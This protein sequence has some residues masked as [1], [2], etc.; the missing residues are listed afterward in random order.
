MAG[1][2]H[3]RLPAW[4][5]VGMIGPAWTVRL[6]V[7]FIRSAPTVHYP[8]TLPLERD[9]LSALPLRADN[10]SALPLERDNVTTL[11]LTG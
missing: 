1:N 10:L 9:N 7:R 11:S 2:V 6:D 4:R 8:T 5:G 3:V